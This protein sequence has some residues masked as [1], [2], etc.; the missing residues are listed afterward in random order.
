MS[1]EKITREFDAKRRIIAQV[2]AWLIL[3]CVSLGS[4]PV[5][6]QQ[7][8]KSSPDLVFCPIQKAWVE[9]YVPKPQIR[10]KKPLADVCAPERVKNKFFFEVSQKV[11]LLRFIPNSATAEKLFFDYAEKGKQAFTDK[12]TAPQ[13]APE[14]RLEKSNAEHKST[15]NNFQTKFDKIRSQGFNLAQA[16]RPPTTQT[17][18]L[19]EQFALRNLESISRR[20]APRAPPAISL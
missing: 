19:F 12:I 17:V 7:P 6:G 10:Y 8:S 3:C 18:A 15:G 11:P 20:I 4:I 1:A 16:A 13:N 5:F 9:K 14:S 2:I